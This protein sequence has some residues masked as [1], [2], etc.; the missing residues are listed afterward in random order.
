MLKTCFKKLLFQRERKEMMI[1]LLVF[2]IIQQLFNFKFKIQHYLN[3]FKVLTNFAGTFD[4]EII[5][6]GQARSNF[7]ARLIQ[8]LN[9]IFDF[10]SL[11]GVELSCAHTF[12]KLVEFFFRYV[13][14]DLR[15][16]V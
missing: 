4:R 5:S 12:L 2:Y 16:F 9:F 13:G 15:E 14:R 11:F 8:Q 7:R 6:S 10:L 1:T 3:K